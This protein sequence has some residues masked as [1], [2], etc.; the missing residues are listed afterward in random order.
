MKENEGKTKEEPPREESSSPLCCLSAVNEGGI[1]QEG[2]RKYEERG[3]RVE[4]EGC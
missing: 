4:E 2:D 1:M 3:Q